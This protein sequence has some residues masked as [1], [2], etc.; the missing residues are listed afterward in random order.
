M[1]KPEEI[2]RGLEPCDCKD[3]YNC[4][5]CEF[6]YQ[7]ANKVYAL[8]Y[9]QQLEAKNTQLQELCDN[10]D[11]ALVKQTRQLAEKELVLLKTVE[12][13]VEKTPKWISVEDRLPEDDLPEGSKVKSIK[14]F[15]AIKAKNGITMRTQTR[16][17]RTLFDTR[18]EPF[19]DWEWR[20]SA[21][22]V[23]HW[24]NLPESPEE[25]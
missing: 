23:T 9:I 8:A 13:F 4:N 20:Y 21:G 6:S 22:K 5:G 2:K 19:F 7:C 3:P 1:K 17:R 25:N 16:Y 24:M 14:V 18:G 12:E 11:L 10:L 15:V